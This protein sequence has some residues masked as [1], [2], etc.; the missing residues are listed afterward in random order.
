MTTPDTLRNTRIRLN[1][2]LFDARRGVWHAD[3]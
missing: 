3:P 2:D 1:H